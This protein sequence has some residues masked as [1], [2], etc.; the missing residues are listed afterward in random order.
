MEWWYFQA[1]RALPSLVNPKV[2]YIYRNDPSSA[3]TP[4]IIRLDDGDQIIFEGVPEAAHLGIG[5]NPTLCNL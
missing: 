4:G 1:Q 5:P 2:R 3:E